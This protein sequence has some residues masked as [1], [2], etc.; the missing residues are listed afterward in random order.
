M[1]ECPLKLH[2]LAVDVPNKYNKYHVKYEGDNLKKGYITQW[3]L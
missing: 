1:R 3:G 2:R